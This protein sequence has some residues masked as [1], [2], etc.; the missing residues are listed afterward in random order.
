MRV[1]LALLG[2]VFLAGS[3]AAQAPFEVLDAQIAELDDVTGVWQFTGDPVRVR[4]E[5]A[6]VRAFR[7]RY[8]RRR[9]V[10]TAEGGVVLLRPRERLTARRVLLELE[11]Q[12]VEA[13]E[14]V[15]VA[16]ELEGGTVV[17]EAP[18]VRLD[19]RAQRAEATGGV[20]GTYREV[21]LR[22]AH[23]LVDWGRGEAVARGEPEAVVEGV[24][25]TADLFRADLRRRILSATGGVRITDGRI[26]ATAGELEARS[27]DRL[28]VLRGGVEVV[29]DGDRLVAPEV[30]YAYAEGTIRTVGRTRVVVRP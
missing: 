11:A 1:L 29:R 30:W 6:E 3:A 26:T 2:L 8:D 5:T 18:H 10:V 23:L 13:E 9:Q 21:R 28:A 25:I 15:V 24:R 4:R 20:S 17:L 12:R 22:A 27:A 7:L 16:R 19:L 14:E